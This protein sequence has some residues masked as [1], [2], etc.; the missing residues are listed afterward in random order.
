MA[1]AAMVRETT[2]TAIPITGMETEMGT[3]TGIGMETEMEIEMETA[4]GTTAAEI[5]VLIGVM[6]AGIMGTAA[7]IATIDLIKNA[8]SELF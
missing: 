3:G 1:G 2:T 5:A 6:T 8:L 7:G 4:M